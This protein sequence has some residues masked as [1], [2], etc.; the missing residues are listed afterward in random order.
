MT[1]ILGMRRNSS[2]NPSSPVKEPQLSSRLSSLR[3][4]KTFFNQGG[5]S[6]AGSLQN[7]KPLTSRNEQLNESGRILDTEQSIVMA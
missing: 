2:K 3:S 7:L 4:T 5:Y 1:S 6:S